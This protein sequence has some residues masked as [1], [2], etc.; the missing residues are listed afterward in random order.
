MQSKLLSLNP[1]TSASLPKTR[2]FTKL[3]SHDIPQLL[4]EDITGNL[5]LDMFSLSNL[6]SILGCPQCKQSS[7]MELSKSLKQRL[8]SKMTVKCS[9]LWEHSFRALQKLPFMSQGFNIN[10]IYSIVYSMSRCGQGFAGINRFNALMNLPPP[11]KSN[12][13]YKIVFKL[14]KSVKF[15][16]TWY[17]RTKRV[18]QKSTTK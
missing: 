18:I 2:A 3:S 13:Y 14:K 6:I 11:F 15:S 9:C 17:S 7:C 16:T 8:T 10:Y 5:I 12:N 1:S 4:K